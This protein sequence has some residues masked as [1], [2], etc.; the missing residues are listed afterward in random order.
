MIIN[1]E[2]MINNFLT[3]LLEWEVNHQEEQHEVFS[4]WKQTEM[5]HSEEEVWFKFETDYD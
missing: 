3:I 5:L 1:N 4:G 2:D